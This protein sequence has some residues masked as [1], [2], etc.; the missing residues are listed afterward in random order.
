M[1][2]GFKG[3]EVGVM[4]HKTAEFFMNEYTGFAGGYKA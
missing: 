1:T 3:D 2:F 4:M